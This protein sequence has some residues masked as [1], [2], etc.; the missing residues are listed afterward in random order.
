MNAVTDRTLT[1]GKS[2][3]VRRRDLAKLGGFLPVGEVLAEDHA[4]G[5]RFLD[6][7]FLVRTSSDI[8]EN[9]NVACSVA[10]TMERHTRWSKM[11]RALFP[12]GFAAEPLLNP[13]VVASV[14]A[15]VAPGEMTAAMLSVA[16]L[17]QTASALL[18]VRALRGTWLS[19]RYAPLELVRSYLMLVCWA[20][21]CWSRRIE[22]RG[23]AFVLGRGSAIVPVPVSPGHRER[24]SRA[25]GSGNAR[26]A[27]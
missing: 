9:R 12:L 23:H 7:G 27:A 21:A 4:L 1:V 6:A 17:V 5:R 16:C 8:V 15:A 2:M 3:A 13:I 14:A 24:T 10:R 25:G 22:W 20:R 26:L 19:W 18:A 11:R